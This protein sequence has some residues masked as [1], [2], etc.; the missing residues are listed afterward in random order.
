MSYLRRIPA[1]AVAA[2]LVLAACGGDQTATQPEQT[3]STIDGPLTFTL[4]PEAVGISRDANDPDVIENGHLQV[5]GLIAIGGYPQFGAP[6]Y[7]AGATG[8]LHISTEP[9]FTRDPLAWNFTF[10]LTQAGRDLPEG[11]YQAQVPVMVTAALNSP[12][13]LTVTYT[14]CATGNCLVLGSVRDGSLSTA[15][16][17]TFNPNSSIPLGVGVGAKMFEEWRLFVL[18]GQTVYLNNRGTAGGFGTLSDPYLY[19]WTLPGDAF[20]GSDDD[21]CNLNS[22]LPIHNASGSVQ[23]YRIYASHFGG[24]KQGS[25]QISVN[26][27]PEDCGIY[28]PP[29]RMNGSETAMPPAWQQAY[30]A[31]HGITN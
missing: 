1:A 5:G 21:N 16:S 28:L 27:G 3:G 10:S 7:G 31:K 24:Y 18:P 4:T 13:M 29:L 22:E 6:M 2:A 8:W 25:Y 14:Y 20:Y 19:A 23:E 11:V 12:Q 17:P 26:P 15:T 9:N 30:N